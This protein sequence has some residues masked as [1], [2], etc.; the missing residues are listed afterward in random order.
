MFWISFVI[1]LVCFCLRAAYNHSKFMQRRFV[2]SKHATTAINVNM[3]VLWAAWFSM[4]FWD[5]IRATLPAWLRYAG[6]LLFVA[7]ISLFVFGDI[8]MRGLT[9]G[10]KLVTTGIFSK[11]RHPVYLGFVLWVI[12][13]PV[14]MQGMLTLASAAIWI[15]FFLYWKHLEECELERKYPEYGNY[16]KRTWF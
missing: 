1:C 11:I 12:G 13:F 7:G 10:K 8:A 4:N 5:P 14:F 3:A 6:L 2:G 16:K 9:S 15:S